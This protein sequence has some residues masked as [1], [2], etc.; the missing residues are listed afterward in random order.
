MEGNE[1]ISKPAGYDIRY[2]HVQS[3]WRAGDLKTL[4]QI[5]EIIPKSTVA[6]D[7]G[8]NLNS[9]NHRIYVT[10]RHIN[11]GHAMELADITGINLDAM[12]TLILAYIREREA[13]RKPRQ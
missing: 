2:S 12:M 13:N 11:F 1:T 9:L 5:F 6:R 10:P 8:W 7:L 3:I 4:D